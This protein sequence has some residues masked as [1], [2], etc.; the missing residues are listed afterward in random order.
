M[1]LISHLEQ[2]RPGVSSIPVKGGGWL[3]KKYKRLRVFA[4]AHAAWG[5]LTSQYPATFAQWRWTTAHWRYG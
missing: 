1:H 2:F 5:R 4:K 3:R